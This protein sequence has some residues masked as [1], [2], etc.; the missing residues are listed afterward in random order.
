[1][2]D[3]GDIFLTESTWEMESQPVNTTNE[4]TRSR[5]IPLDIARLIFEKVMEDTPIPV[6]LALVS[7]QVQHW[8][9]PF[10]YRHLVFCN[11]ISLRLFYRTFRERRHSHTKT[12]SFFAEH[13]KTL[14]LLSGAAPRVEQMV[15]IGRGLKSLRAV[16]GWDS[17]WGRLILGFLADDCSGLQ[18][19]RVVDT[20]KGLR[21]TVRNEREAWRDQAEKRRRA[22][23][24]DNLLRGW[25]GPGAGDEDP[26]ED[27]SISNQVSC[28]GRKEAS[29]DPFPYKDL[30]RFSISAYALRV[31]RINLAHRVFRDLTHLDIYYCL[32]FDWST[33][34][35]M[36]RLTHLA[37]DMLTHVDLPFTEMKHAM[38]ELCNHCRAMPQLK[39]IIF[40]CINWWNRNFDIL[41]DEDE[42]VAPINFSTEDW[43][44]SGPLI[45]TTN[46]E[47]HLHYLTQLCLGMRDP[48][49]VL[50]IISDTLPNSHLMKEYMVDFIWPK[51]SYDWDFSVPDHVHRESWDVAEDII[52]KRKKDRIERRRKAGKDPYVDGDEESQRVDGEFGFWEAVQRRWYDVHSS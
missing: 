51:N 26:Q 2:S 41:D 34:T 32:L 29:E 39:V 24:E 22:G 38:E 25:I 44:R 52:E 4:W 11:S 35:S 42:V 8:V 50:G 10:I 27:D 14:H 28:W 23:T 36:R 1:M 30:S 47:H 12:T 37:V 19:V 46:D 33:L 13:V 43:D 7:R 49:V 3:A 6:H 16:A 5:S 9:E 18:G 15:A 48:R 17:S 45:T 21:Y 31:F 20:G 40:A